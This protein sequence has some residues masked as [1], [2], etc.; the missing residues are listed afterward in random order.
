MPIA[1]AMKAL[2]FG[3]VMLAILWGANDNPKLG[4]SVSDKWL[5]ALLWGA[6]FWTFASFLIYQAKVI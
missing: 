3:F 6:V 1:V 4:G 5:S 2:T